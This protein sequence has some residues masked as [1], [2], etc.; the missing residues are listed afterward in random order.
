MLNTYRECSKRINAIG[1]KKKENSVRG[2]GCS[3]L[4]LRVLVLNSVV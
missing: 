2:N 4:P 1:K 3:K